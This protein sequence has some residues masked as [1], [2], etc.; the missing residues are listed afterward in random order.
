MFIKCFFLH[1]ACSNICSLLIPYVK[2]YNIWCPVWSNILTITF[3]NTSQYSFCW[4]NC[5]TINSTNYILHNFHNVKQQEEIA[6]RGENKSLLMKLYDILLIIIL[7]IWQI[8]S[9]DILSNVC[10]YILIHCTCNSIRKLFQ[11]LVTHCLDVILLSVLTDLFFF[12]K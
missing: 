3:T 1:K 7:F 5:K 9:I 11:S 4:C 12:K 6:K 2:T 8:T 10:S